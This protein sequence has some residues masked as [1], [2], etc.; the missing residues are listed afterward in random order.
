MY[1][2]GYGAKNVHSYEMFPSFLFRL[3]KHF[4]RISRTLVSSNSTLNLST[5]VREVLSNHFLLLGCDFVRLGIQSSL[6]RRK[7]AMPEET[8]V[9][10]KCIIIKAIL[11]IPKAFALH[12]F[13]R[14]VSRP[15]NL[16]PVQFFYLFMLFPN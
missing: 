7:I 8:K 14:P 16:N 5:Q 10:I 11:A 9:F 13:L 15:I 4:F 6:H 1:S 3:N 12:N 2:W